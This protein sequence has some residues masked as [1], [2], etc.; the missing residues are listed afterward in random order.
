MIDPSIDFLLQYS[1]D[2]AAPPIPK[3]I[4]HFGARSITAIINIVPEV[5]SKIVKNVII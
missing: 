2:P 3:P 1:L 5:N 4:H